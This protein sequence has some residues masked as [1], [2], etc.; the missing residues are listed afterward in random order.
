M[1]NESSIVDSWSLEL[2]MISGK[3]RNMNIHLQGI[4]NVTN[5]KFSFGTKDIFRASNKFEMKF[6]INRFLL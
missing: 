4:K 2:S 6:L 3:I 5:N 1:F